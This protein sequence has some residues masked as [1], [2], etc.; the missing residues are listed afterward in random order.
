[1]I[2]KLKEITQLISDIG[3]KDSE[4][5]AF[6]SGCIR[7]LDE[8]VEA[9]LR[10]AIHSNSV[11]PKAPDPKA[12]NWFT[13]RNNLKGNCEDEDL[14]I[15]STGSLLAELESKVTLDHLITPLFY[16]HS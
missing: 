11:S 1:M 9:R 15:K 14:A 16:L 12:P 5:L 2:N 13:R 10:Y 3:A 8:V 7:E 6:I 4:Q